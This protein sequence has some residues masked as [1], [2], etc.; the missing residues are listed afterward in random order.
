[1][2]RTGRETEAGLLVTSEAYR[3]LVASEASHN[4]VA[5]EAYHILW[6]SGLN[7]MAVTDDARAASTTDRGAS[8]HPNI[9]RA[10]NGDP[11]FGKIVNS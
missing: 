2:I 4:L 10:R 11:C 8:S 1:M 7:R 9:S 3:S 5:P 6:A